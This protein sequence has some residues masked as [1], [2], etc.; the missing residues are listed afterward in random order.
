L[1]NKAKLKVSNVFVF[2]K[3][4]SELVEI[5]VFFFALFIFTKHL[6]HNI[7]WLFCNSLKK[8]LFFD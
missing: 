1:K 2:I 8:T 3:K 7:R 6:S 4:T 5:Q